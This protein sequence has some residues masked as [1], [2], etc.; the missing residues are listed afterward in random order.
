MLHKKIIL[1]TRSGILIAHLGAHDFAG[2]TQFIAA[3]AEEYPG[4]VPRQRQRLPLLRLLWA[5]R[6]N[7]LSFRL[8]S[9]NERD[10]FGFRLA[11]QK[12]LVCNTADT[13]R[14]V[15]LERYDGDE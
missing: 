4:S 5:L 13:A 11:R 7:I 9:A 2:S 15:F 1:S 10:C 8:Q 3:T 6:R 14:R 12:Y